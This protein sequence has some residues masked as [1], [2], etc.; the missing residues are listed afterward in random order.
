MSSCLGLYIQNNLIKYA[1]VTKERDNL[2]VEAFGVKFYDNINEAIHQIVSETYSYKTPI[3][4]NLSEESYNY[5]YMFSLLNKNDLK[6]SIDTEFDSFCYEKGYNRNTLE[7]RYALVPDI[8]DK[9]KI[10]VI[11]ISSNKIEVNQKMQELEG[12]TLS[13]ISPLPIAIT[14]IAD[15][16]EKE[17]AIILNIEEKTTVT[18]IIDQK[19]YNVDKIEQGAE[20][21][22]NSISQKENSYSK[23]YEICKNTTIYT[24]EGK[25]LI[26]EE[27]LYLEDIMPT[28]YNIV[29]SVRNIVDNSIEKISKIYITGTGSMINNVD[30]YF[31]EYFPE[32]KC[33]ILKPYFIPE[34]VKI[35]MKDYIEVNSAI[36]L[37][38][39]GLGYGIKTLNFKKPSLTDKLPDWMKIEIGGKKEDGKKS[40]KINLGKM[41][42]SF[43][44]KGEFD[45][46]EKWLVRSLSAILA[47]VIIYSG[48]ALFL[49]GQTDKKLKEVADVTGHT[50]EQ[51][52][53]VEKDIEAVNNKTTKYEEVLRNLEE[54]KNE[55]SENRK[56]KDSI[57]NF[58]TALM[59]MPQ[60][61]TITSI[62][63]TTDYTIRIE[64]QSKEYSQLGYLIGNLKTKNILYNVTSSS[65]V[66]QNDIIKVVIEGSLFPE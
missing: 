9:Q 50:I 3:S 14:N 44:L 30:L 5:F 6:K 38:M 66:K 40:K 39:Q 8:Q 16:K 56:I 24:M 37:G 18:T 52:N 43:D 51:I 41:N 58:L 13:T 20:T 34:T 61:V 4:T 11:H 21:I 15:I 28:L 2:K 26:Q 7:T 47:F 19:I 25:D 57:P 27:N 32:C 49:K 31:Q 29:Q 62:T 36:A 17:N 1:K 64:A 10:K 35:N 48:F 45:N 23:A 63:N 46:I 42:L 59:T 60:G 54:Y 22:L 33:E 12:N 65:G 53:L 55:S